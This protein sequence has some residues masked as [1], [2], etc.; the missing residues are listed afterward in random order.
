MENGQQSYSRQGSALGRSLQRA[1]SSLTLQ[2]AST[3]PTQD[4]QLRH[5]AT[6][7]ITHDQE[8][9]RPCCGGMWKVQQFVGFVIGL[10]CFISLSVFQPIKDYPSANAMLGITLLCGAFWVFEVGPI[11]ITALL[12]VVMMPIMGI[13][14]SEIAAQSYWNMIQM[15]VIGTYLVDIALEEVHLPRRVVLKLLLITGVVQPALLLFSFMLLCWV[16]S[17]FCN[18]IAVTLMITPFAIEI[19]SSAEEQ[20]RDLMASDVSSSDEA[21][22]EGFVDASIEE[23]QR[24]S[25]GLLLGIAYS[26]TA[27][28]MATLTGT[29]TNEVLYGIGKVPDQLSYSK[30]WVY[31]AGTSFATFVIGYIV[32]YL[33]YCRGLQLKTLT[34]EMFEQEHEELVKEIGPF[35]RDE[36]CVGLIQLLQ[37]LLLLFRPSIASYFISPY[38]ETLI[39]DPTLAVLPALLLFFIPSVVRPRQALL[40]W[41]DVHDK[42][43]FG[44]LLLIGGGFAIAHGFSE[45]GLNIAIGQGL[46]GMTESVHPFTLNLMI[47]FM[48]S[49]AT[50]MFS[51][52]GTA[53]TMLPALYAAAINAVH[54]PFAFVLPA[55]LGCSLGFMLPTATPANV[56]VLAKSQELSR[57][58]KIRDFFCSGLPLNFLVIVIGSVLTYFSGGTAFDALS[59]FPRW[60]CDEGVTCLWVP[61]PGTVNSGVHVLSQ[62]CMIRADDPD[63]TTCRLWNGTIL[64]TSAYLVM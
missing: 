64:N 43:D 31:A 20:A 62:A 17:M 41:P 30:W 57:S 36:F 42:F 9:L 7:P 18:N 21:S 40:A 4:K 53:T 34:R 27:G 23:V 13:T 47:I 49:I 29:I 24:F 33:R 12:P 5:A 59:P 58:L 19:M 39:S 54:N 44:L 1:G 56:V 63:A 32:L 16:L 37:F 22:D 52:I 51:A 48:T 25:S 35:S 15:L 46:A 38:G 45:S 11:Y 28:G 2:R 60:A 6:M 55:T 14:S 3:L 50:Q 10:T 8:N 61:V 26:S